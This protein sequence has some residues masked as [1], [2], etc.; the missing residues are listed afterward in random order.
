MSVK[1]NSCGI[2]KLQDTMLGLLCCFIRLCE[3]NNLKY[4]LA[5]GTCLG[6]VRHSGFIPWDDDLDVFMPR[7]DYEILWKKYKD[8]TVETKYTLTRTTKEKN[9]HH[10]VMQLVDIDTTFIQKR[11]VNEDIEHGV[12]IDIVPLD[13][14]PD[15]AISRISQIY[16]AIIFSVF[17]IQCKQEYNGGKTTKFVNFITKI[18]LNIIKN[19]DKRNKIWEKAERKMTKYS[20]EQ[21]TRVACITST[22]HELLHPFPKKWMGMKKAQFEDIYACIPS[23]AE[24]YLNMMYGD[25]MQLPPNEKRVP[26]H[27]TVYID[28]NHSYKTYKGIY[29]CKEIKDGKTEDE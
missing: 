13:A 18:L 7:S 5:G 26:R 6:A 2:A 12:Y 4:W 11:N 24:Q 27:N 9:F 8:E 21:S 3:E 20:W 14:A 16:N 19:P 29:Y 22:L 25:Y 23:Q 15:N 1:D 28:L 10:R 17:N